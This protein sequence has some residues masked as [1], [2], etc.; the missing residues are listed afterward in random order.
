MLRPF[1]LTLLVLLSACASRQRPPAPVAGVP[2]AVEPVAVE[3][4][5]PLDPG[6]HPLSREE[7]ELAR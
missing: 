4:V 7:E 2:V 5:E 6:I 3:P 1:A